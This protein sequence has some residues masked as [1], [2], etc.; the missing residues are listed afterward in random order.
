MFSTFQAHLP[1]HLDHIFRYG[2][3][4]A[5]MIE[6]SISTL[7]IIIIAAY[8]AF[9]IGLGVWL[10]R[11]NNTSDDYF[12]AGR[13]MNW[14]VIGGSLYASN[15]STTTLIG[16][17]GAAYTYGVVFYNYEWMAV[18]VLIIFSLFF[19]RPVLKSTIYTIPEFFE[20]RYS[21][22]TGV[23]LSILTLFL[24]IVIDT[25]GGL[26]AGALLFRVILPDASL[27]QL[28][29]GLALVSGTYTIAGGL[30]AVMI[31]D[32][33]QAFILTATSAMVAWLAFQSAGDWSTVMET[34]L[35]KNPLALDLIR[36]LDDTIMPWPTLI[37]GLPILGFYFWCT[38]QFMAQRVLAA[39]TE[40]DG[41]L[42]LLFAGLLKLPTLFLMVLPGVAALTLYPNLENG[43]TVYALLLFE[44]LPSGLLGLALVGFIAA[45]MSQIDSTLNSAS[46]LIT[47][48]FV[49]RRYPHLSSHTLMRI[50]QLATLIF[51]LLAMVW[52]P[53][54]ER[55]SSIFQYLQ[56][57]LSYA[58]GPIVVL[59]FAAVFW[60]RANQ[61]GA[62]AAIIVGLL[63]SAGLFFAK[64]YQISDLN[65]LYAAPITVLVS[66]IALA[67][68]SLVTS[69]PNETQKSLT[70]MS[71]RRDSPQSR[72]YIT[73]VV[74][75]LVLT[76][77]V[78]WPW[79]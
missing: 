52:A 37:L 79:I 38:N 59:F 5:V 45:L 46:T 64:A 9:S 62:H 23:Y 47:M 32:V 51:M 12:L 61:H 71:S 27:W 33:I 50:G 60:A 31:T 74:L 58:V 73:S 21:R 18:V 25:A 1:A 30:A 24:N 11:K 44:L 67:V 48:D 75:L 63:V 41:Q 39:R 72:I 7:D 56:D 69:P 15:I 55:F 68:G 20:K 66:S 8:L 76:M 13:K 6:T 28:I 70:Y 65:N 19:V 40:V 29:S 17:S 43:D 16:L 78:I 3:F 49:R 22:A 2:I 77:I 54:I 57:I 10:G 42:G 53:Q 4:S 26:Y 14:F 35:A 36:P 34:A